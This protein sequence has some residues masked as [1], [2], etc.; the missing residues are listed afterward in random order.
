MLWGVAK[1]TPAND[2]LM[3]TI[4]SLVGSDPGGSSLGENVGTHNLA[5]DVCLAGWDSANH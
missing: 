1:G 5:M 2:Y 4:I 3:F